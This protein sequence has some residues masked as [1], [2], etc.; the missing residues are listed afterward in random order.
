[1]LRLI[2][3]ICDFKNK[4]S[5]RSLAPPF[6][7]KV[8]LGAPVR[9][10]APSRRFAVVTNLLRSLFFSISYGKEA[11]GVCLNSALKSALLTE[12]G[13]RAA[14]GRGSAFFFAQR[15]KVGRVKYEGNNFWVPQAVCVTGSSPCSGE[16][17]RSKVHFAPAYFF[18]CD[19]K[20]KP[21]AR[22]LAPP[23]TQKVTL[24]APVRLQ[25]PSRRFAVVTNLLRSLFFS[26]SYGK[27][28][29]G[30]CL[31]SALKSALLT[32]KGRRD[33]GGRGSAFFFAQRRGKRS[34]GGFRA[35]PE[36]LHATLSLLFPVKRLL[37]GAPDTASRV[38][39]RFKSLLRGATSEQAT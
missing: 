30:V 36:N 5:A 2:F 20:N 3:F 24:G 37:Y 7:Q 8:T 23:F 33:V 27:E 1:M 19:F 28:A 29:V 6:T 13:R 32:E 34:G 18:I 4:P 17:R 26:I 21:S 25:A 15:S 9:L 31:N 39:H 10:Q 12:K 22:S 38:C 11:V 14:G 35:K 16:P